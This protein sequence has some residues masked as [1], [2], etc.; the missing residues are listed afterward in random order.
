MRNC[1]L[2]QW[3]LQNYCWFWSVMWSFWCF[4]RKGV[5][6][7]RRKNGRKR[8]RK[9]TIKH[10]K[11]V[12]R[13]CTILLIPT[14]PRLEDSQ[15][16]NILSYGHW[17]FRAVASFH[18][19]RGTKLVQVDSF[20]RE[21]GITFKKNLDFLSRIR[22]KL[23]VSCLKLSIFW[24]FRSK[25]GGADYGPVFSESCHKIKLYK[26]VKTTTDL[27]EILS[28]ITKPRCKIC[29]SHAMIWHL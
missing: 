10:W 12:I 17:C 19:I 9:E 13:L 25:W 2:F 27:K 24:T 26:M 23:V 28:K 14:F 3:L 4:G 6:F 21:V 15:K 22:V 7:D 18:R 20:P 1:I 11:S 16:L 29:P 8:L 5:N